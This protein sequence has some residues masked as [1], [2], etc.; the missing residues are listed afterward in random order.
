MGLRELARKK[1][2]PPRVQVLRRPINDNYFVDQTLLWTVL[3]R[4]GVRLRVHAAIRQIYV[5]MQAVCV[6]LEHGEFSLEHVGC[7]ARLFGNDGIASLEFDVVLMA[8]VPVAV[9]CFS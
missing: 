3:A 8:V 6:W 1:E 2:T 4:F 9:K 5:G 7:A